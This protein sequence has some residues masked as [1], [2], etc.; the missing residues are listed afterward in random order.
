VINSDGV[1]R[2][3][4]LAHAA[5]LLNKSAA[6]HHGRANLRDD[7]QNNCARV[8]RYRDGQDPGPGLPPVAGK[9]GTSSVTGNCNVNVDDH[10]SGD[11]PNPTT[12]TPHY[13]PGDRKRDDQWPHSWYSEPQVDL[14]LIG[15]A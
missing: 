9:S 12:R 4:P 8:G 1:T 13:C 5:S 3:Y 10:E 7:A 2:S 15:G 11:S 6:T 14:A